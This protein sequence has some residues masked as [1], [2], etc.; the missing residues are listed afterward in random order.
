MVG[1]KFFKQITVSLSMLGCA[2]AFAGAPRNV[3][4]IPGVPESKNKTQQEF[5]QIQ[6]EIIKTILE[7]HE[8]K[9]RDEAVLIYMA[10]I[11]NYHRLPNELQAQTQQV[12]E[13][14]INDWKDAITYEEPAFSKAIET[15]AQTHGLDYNESVILLLYGIS[16][17]QKPEQ[18][19]AVKVLSTKNI[20]TLQKIVADFMIPQ[21]PATPTP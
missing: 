19:E 11:A 7:K 18:L 8:L 20:N 1:L 2:L 15:L 4:I 12:V 5:Y 13:A 10:N 3:R 9:V 17:Q 6:D 16:Y 14:W 21:Q